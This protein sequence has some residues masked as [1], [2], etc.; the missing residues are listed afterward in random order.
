M[1]SVPSTRRPL[2]FCPALS[3]GSSAFFPRLSKILPCPG[4]KR[5]PSRTTRPTNGPQTSRL[6][7]M[8]PGVCNFQKV[9]LVHWLRLCE[10]CR[11][12]AAYYTPVPLKKAEDLDAWDADSPAFNIH[13][14]QPVWYA[15]PLAC[16][17]KKSP[18]QLKVER[19]RKQGTLSQAVW[20]WVANLYLR[21]FPIPFCFSS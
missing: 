16:Q 7:A 10:S 2:E 20:E 5:T 9:Q 14:N 11:F 4:R 13:G 17:E 21:Y 3:S 6:V 8:W 18:A 19:M 15:M 12:E 1:R